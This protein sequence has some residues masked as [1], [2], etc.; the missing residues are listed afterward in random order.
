[1]RK[2]WK[3]DGTILTFQNVYLFSLEHVGIIIYCFQ[4]LQVSQNSK[5]KGESSN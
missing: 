4:L 3:L 5:K 1:M 2:L